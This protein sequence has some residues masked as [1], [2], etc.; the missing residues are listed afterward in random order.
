[1]PSPR[2]DVASAAGR[3]N[4]KLLNSPH[5]SSRDYNGG[6]KR[7]GEFAFDE[8]RRELRTEGRV[9]L[10]AGQALDILSLLLERPG[11]IVSREEIRQRLWQ[12]TTVD[13]EHS[14]DVTISRLRSVLRDTASAPRYIQTIPRK[15][16][17]FVE[18]VR[19]DAAPGPTVVTRPW[20]RRVVTY[21]LVAIIAAAAATGFVRSRYQRFVPAHAP[22][23]HSPRTR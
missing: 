12:D 21:G 10:A 5:Q 18:A 15:G 22:Q 9:I 19:I 6:V 2:A 8:H 13:F 7:F 17:R 14:L 3:V 20:I 4:S 16:Y 1:M 11:E 23:H